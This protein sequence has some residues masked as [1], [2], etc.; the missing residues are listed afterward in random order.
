MQRKIHILSLSLILCFMSACIKK[1]KDDSQ[2]VL[3]GTLSVDLDASEALI[4]TQESLIGNFIADALFEGLKTKGTPVDFVLANAGSIRFDVQKRPDGIYRKGSIT[5]EMVDEMLPFSE[6]KIVLMQLS[7]LQLKEIIERSLAQL[8]LE[9]GSFLQLSKGL[10]LT[11]DLS[12]QAQILDET[13]SPPVIQTAGQRIISLQF[14]ETPI[15]DNQLY[16][17]AVADYIANGNDGYVTFTGIPSSE[18]VTTEIS[19]TNLVR[20]QII[21]D[22]VI[23]PVIEGRINF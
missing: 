23:N 14:N 7:G 9:K 16:K 17:V 13:V 8:P 6:N 10:K 19:Q 15:Q 12:K 1:P 21:I 2:Q 18:K 20:E 3:I 5:S 11:A 22:A 4:R